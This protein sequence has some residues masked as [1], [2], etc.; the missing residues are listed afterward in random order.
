MD[1]QSAQLIEGEYD[2]IYWGE[3]ENAVLK[4]AFE[5]IKQM[6]EKYDR[7]RLL[8]L[9]CGKGR[10]ISSFQI[11]IG[12]SVRNAGIDDLVYFRQLLANGAKFACEG[13]ENISVT[14]IFEETSAAL[15][16][17][18]SDVGESYLIEIKKSVNINRDIY[19][20]KVFRG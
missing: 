7:K 3:S 10:L 5:A 17:N 18:V 19:R 4:K 20:T 14:E 9:G 1:I 15:E 16:R 6:P 11:C 13:R 2:S 8:N 12:I